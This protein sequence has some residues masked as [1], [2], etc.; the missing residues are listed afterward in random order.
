VT[1]L[2]SCK[3][4]YN[5]SVT[6]KEIFIF[7]CALIDSIV[8]DF[9][10]S[11]FGLS[12]AVSP[13]YSPTSPAYSPASPAYSPM[14]GKKQKKKFAALPL[15]RNVTPIP[16][17][18]ASSLPS[19]PPP[20]PPRPPP[21]QTPPLPPRTIP[22]SSP[23]LTSQESSPQVI[24][25]TTRR[26]VASQSL[27]TQP[28]IAPQSL[29]G[30]PP[31]SLK[32]SPPLHQKAKFKNSV[33]RRP[34]A[35]QEQPSSTRLINS[36]AAEVAPRTNY[37]QPQCF[38]QAAAPLVLFAKSP[39]PPPPPP[40]AAVSLSSAPPEAATVTLMAD[41]APELTVRKSAAA[42]LREKA[43]D[44]ELSSGAKTSIQAA[45]ESSRTR[46]AFREYSASAD[47][48]FSF[49]GNPALKER[50]AADEI[51]LAH[52][53]GY[54]FW[55]NKDAGGPFGSAYGPGGPFG[56][57]YG[58]GGPFGSAYG[59][60][61]PFG[62][63]YD[64]AEIAFEDSLS[65]S[66]RHSIRRRRGGS[67]ISVMSLKNRNEKLDDAKTTSTPVPISHGLYRAKEGKL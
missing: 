52:H 3:C 41:K 1:T 30:L 64:M 39:P 24:V 57:A 59:P 5:N 6:K 48:G 47:V 53:A 27:P 2:P 21:S 28:Q 42:G 13:A 46:R 29:V 10:A 22:P 61:G 23:P 4:A 65:L 44:Y 36:V 43:A 15:S 50:S 14:L 63:A 38:N 17:M 9:S 26:S 55:S 11:G 35:S 12:S 32:E 51:R 45:S 16:E 18:K 49:G 54:E 33:R 8:F 34:P 60:G 56:S 31:Q 19:A 40:G 66:A 58:P 7:S 20:L 67:H 37:S 62:S 25:L